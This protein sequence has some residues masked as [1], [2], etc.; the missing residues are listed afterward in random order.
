MIWVFAGSLA[1][2]LALAGVARLLALGPDEPVTAERAA[3]AAEARLIGFTARHAVAAT[4]GRAALVL[5]AG[6]EAALV[7]ASGVELALRRLAW[8]L[9]W[10]RQGESIVIDSGE[11]MFGRVTLPCDDALLT[12]LSGPR[13]TLD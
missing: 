5:G 11:A 12:R 1:A 7:K 3:A 9:D 4:D 6:G 8:P 10:H 2:V 13:D